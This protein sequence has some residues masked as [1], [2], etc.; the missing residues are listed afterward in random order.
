MIGLPIAPSPSHR[1][2]GGGIVIAILLGGA[3]LC[4]A[5]V[6]MAFDFTPRAAGPELA[7]EQ[8]ASA[9]WWPV[10]H[11]L[12]PFAGPVDFTPH[13]TQPG[14]NYSLLASD[15]CSGCHGVGGPASSG[16]FR[17]HPTWAGSMMANAMRDPLFLAALD[18]ANHDVPGVGDYCLRCHTSQGWYGGRVVKAGYG[19]PNNDV[20]KGAAACLLEGSYDAP[21]AYS[22]YSGLSCHF[23]HRQMAQGP[24]GEPL[25]R[26]GAVWLD[27][28][29]CAGASEPCRRGPYNYTGGT[30][31]PHA[32]KFS[33]FH[34]DSAM[35]GQCHDVTTPDIAGGP[36]KTLKLADGSDTGVPFPIERTFSEWQRSAFSAPVSGKN[37]QDC[38]MP[39]SEDPQATACTLGG[40]PN[41]SGNLP[42]HAFAGGNTWIPGMIKG[43]Y[44]DTSAIPGSWQGI[45][46][47]ASFDQAI[48]W[49]RQLLQSA[50]A[51][52]T[53]I[54]AYSAPTL[55]VAGSIALQVEVTNLSGHKLPSGYGEGRRMWINV[56]VHDAG[57]SLLAES[58]AYDLASAVLGSD[59]QAHVYEVLQGI[60]NHNGSSTCDVVNGSG[61]AMFHFALNDCVAKDNRI[62]PLGFRPAT[63]DDPNGYEVRPVGA[64]YPETAPGS[65]TLVNVDRVAY[66]FSVPA[67]A[68]GPFT[69]TARLYYQTSSKDYIDFLRDEAVANAFP[70]ENQM[71]SGA[72]NRPFVVGPQGRTRGEYMHQLW[73]NPS[74][75]PVQPGYGKSPPELIGVAAA[76][77]ADLLFVDGF[78]V[79]TPPVA[80]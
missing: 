76:N 40:Y 58:G 2:R 39:S 50:A 51:V 17:P 26:N 22:D 29:P 14:L 73:N 63:L 78:E 64:I 43:E 28:Q 57:G 15:D 55:S 10:A 56:Q 11:Q 38:H 48:G 35:C 74:D 5:V 34:T 27:D 19:Q 7:A 70:G 13:G 68:V 60:F 24:A 53:T 59:P 1:R 44:S 71:C 67:G 16:T 6:A 30:R 80:R 65:G 75:D 31:P 33:P 46:R 32:W 49:A 36:L 21:D 77:S 41:R 23:C 79:R 12:A 72:S 52:V 9:S 45:G 42:T 47:Q 25:P 4:T 61:K 54:S 8:S 18:V 62:P 20:T 3:L 37:C 66:R 69:A